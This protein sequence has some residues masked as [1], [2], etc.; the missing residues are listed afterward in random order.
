MDSADNFS[1]AFN[2]T[3]R[4]EVSPNWDPMDPDVIE[5]KCDTKEKR[6]KV[7]Y[8]NYSKDPGGLT[9]YGISQSRNPDIDVANLDLEEATN[10]YF[11]KYWL[12]GRCDVLPLPVSIIHFDGCVNV[13]LTQA[14]KILQ[15]SAEVTVDGIIGRQTTSA[16]WNF[17]PSEIVKRIASFRRD[18]Y[19]SIVTEKPSQRI[20][21]RGW[22]NRVNDVEK[23]SLELI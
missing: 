12:A 16:V 13:G 4:W 8:V 19:N 23:F 9:K 17:D 2:H 7:G 3:M 6:K 14:S 5:G 20:F 21:L 22:F 11:K 1:I 15:K 18:Y 10:I